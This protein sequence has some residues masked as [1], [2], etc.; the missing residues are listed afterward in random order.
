MVDHIQVVGLHGFDGSKRVPAGYPPDV[1][2]ELTQALALIVLGYLIGSLP[3]GVIVARLTGGTDP[4]TIGSGRTGGTNALRAM[5]PR[6]ALVVGLL[7]VAKGCVPVL[8]A[9][10]A[11]AGPAVGALTGV[12]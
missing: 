6:R 12:A 2:P 8:I 9:I 3:M 5:G 11:G 10:W 4:R 7:D 1:S